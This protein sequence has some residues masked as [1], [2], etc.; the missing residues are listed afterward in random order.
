[1]LSKLRESY[2]FFQYAHINKGQSWF[3]ECASLRVDCVSQSKASM[4][5]RRLPNFKDSADYHDG[6]PSSCHADSF[7][8]LE[9]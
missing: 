1:M 6:P 3:W 9:H 4:L 5:V 2:A 8:T 7:L